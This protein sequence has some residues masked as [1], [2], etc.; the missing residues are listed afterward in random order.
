MAAVLHVTAH[1]GQVHEQCR[2][3]IPSRFPHIA[4]LGGDIASTHEDSEES[5]VVRGS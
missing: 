3:P 5:P 1:V 4:D 2:H